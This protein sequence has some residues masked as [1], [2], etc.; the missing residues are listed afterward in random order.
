MFAIRTMHHSSTSEMQRQ[1]VVTGIVRS[2]G[3]V[4]QSTADTDGRIG[5]VETNPVSSWMSAEATTIRYVKSSTVAT[6]ISH[7]SDFRS[8]QRNPWE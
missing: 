1:M 4:G 7:R 2:F 6:S 5:R 3:R 8:P